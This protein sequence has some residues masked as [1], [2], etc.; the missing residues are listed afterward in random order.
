MLAQLGSLVGAT[1]REH[2]IFA[3]YGGEEFAFILPETGLDGAVEL[4]ERLRRR[5]AR[6]AFE[7]DGKTQPVAVSI[8]VATFDRAMEKAADLIE[9]ADFQL[10]RAK[11][12]GRNRVEPP[13]PGAGRG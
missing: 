4:A 5:I 8:G 6:S 1:Q 3:R 11:N 7:F 13:Y 12:G 2:D 9:A 10:Y